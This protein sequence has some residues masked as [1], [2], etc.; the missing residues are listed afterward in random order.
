M[1]NKVVREP[2]C[3]DTVGYYS[4]SMDTTLAQINTSKEQA[5]CPWFHKCLYDRQNVFSFL[6]KMHKQNKEAPSGENEKQIISK[7][8]YSVFVFV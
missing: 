5:Y 7:H 1:P 8:R 6:D 4:F 3:G 2:E